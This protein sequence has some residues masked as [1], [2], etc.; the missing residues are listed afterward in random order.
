VNPEYQ[1][2]TTT[3]LCRLVLFGPVA[4]PSDTTEDLFLRYRTS[5]ID[6]ALVPG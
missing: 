1:I 3:A 4:L 5:T 2:T 6:L